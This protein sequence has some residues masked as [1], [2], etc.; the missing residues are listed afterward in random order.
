MKKEF[1]KKSIIGDGEEKQ[2][3]KTRFKQT[4]F[5][6]KEN[7]G[8]LFV[9]GIISFVFS[10]PSFVFL[11]I[12][13]YQ[14]NSIDMSVSSNVLSFY[15]T[16]FLYLIPC[17]AISGIGF[18]SLLY[19]IREIAV[20]NERGFAVYFEGMKKYFLLGFL[21][22][23]LIGV[24]QFFMFFDIVYY[25]CSI[26]SIFLKSLLVFAGVLQFSIVLLFVMFVICLTLNYQ[27]KFKD[28]MKNSLVFTFRTFFRSLVIIC[29]AI[30]P[31]AGF[32]FSSGVFS[33]IYANLLLMCGF[34]CSA[35]I[36]NQYTLYLFDKLINKEIFKD[37]YRRGLFKEKFDEE[38]NDNY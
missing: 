13:S 24:S 21:C 31:W 8:Y 2:L 9:C 23:L 28:L 3:P 6:L 19:L 35:L 14:K 17:V 36:V 15:A 27:L 29:L 10:V 25:S 26:Y 22:F 11:F 7:F 33:I 16:T 20:G 4:F 18:V 5:L 30:L 32:L 38:K 37:S 1:L 12:F 34:N